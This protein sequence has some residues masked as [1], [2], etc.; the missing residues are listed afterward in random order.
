[1]ERKKRIRTLGSTLL[2]I[3]AGAMGVVVGTLIY[4]FAPVQDLIPQPPTPTATPPAP[5]PSPTPGPEWVVTFEHR[6]PA[7]PLLT[8]RNTYEIF[9]RC[10]NGYAET[11]RGEYNVSGTALVNRNRVYLRSAGVM[12]ASLDGS[13]VGTIH[14]DQLLGAAL[15]LKYATLDEAET[16]RE[17]CTVQVSVNGRP[18][19]QMSP[20]IPRERIPE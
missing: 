17:S 15:T 11:W 10:A 20:A 7:D 3:G 6:F 4:T 16:A 12:S 5:L 13:P 8:G 1:M 19:S 2:L 14:P 9:A 18:A